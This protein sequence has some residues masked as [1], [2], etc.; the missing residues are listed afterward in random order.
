MKL[1]SPFGTKKKSRKKNSR[2][3]RKKNASRFNSLSWILL[4]CIVLLVAGI[5]LLK[6]AETG[7]GQATLL[8]LGSDQAY[9]EVQ[10][11]IEAVLVEHF[12]DFRPG[13]AARAES[14]ARADDY[15]WRAPALGPRAQVRCR[16]VALADARP[17]EQIQ[18][19]LEQSLGQVGGKVLWAELVFSRDRGKDQ[20]HCGDIANLL[21]L[22]VGVSGKPTHTLLLYRAPKCPEVV[23]G[24]GDGLSSWQQ[25]C[26]QMKGPVVALIIDDWGHARNEA[27]KSLLKLPIPL[28][29]AVLPKQPYSR[30]FA[31]KG[32]AL[33]QPPDASVQAAN[34]PA[35]S[36]RSAR[37]AAGCFV[38]LHLGT[39][40]PKP[41]VKRREVILHLPMEPQG[42]PET[43]P[44]P[45]PLLVGMDEAE[46]M[47]ILEE[48]LG[49]L[50]GINGL[51]NHM[52]SAATSDLATMQALMK[53]LNRKGL[54]FV[55]SLTTARS[56]A[57]EQALLDGVPA[58]RNRIF[59]DFDNKN[60]ATI[61]ANLNTLVRSARG[62]GFALGIGHVHAAT[63]R[64]LAREIPRL[65]E[66]GVRF[67]T[68][69]EMLALQ[70]AKQKADLP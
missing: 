38:E 50:P 7:P 44:G 36:G 28:T 13:P 32:T 15:D 29:M 55:D 17:F 35:I 65:V 69:S 49:N 31:L 2:R 6:W 52:G 45:D 11:G 20:A 34:T 70:E 40:C 25:W 53:V 68:V 5:G 61:I 18:W 23:W 54:Y 57:F 19:D 48:A 64:V 51:N 43:N 37:L 4:V 8:A 58:L 41:L 10:T 21:R 16:V 3:R 67:V 56:V 24:D 46:I 39:D 27:T 26:D 22:D 47:R 62:R 14:G 59:L 1:P 12:P 30:H 66:E 33:V 9:A 42:Y 63:A 60:E